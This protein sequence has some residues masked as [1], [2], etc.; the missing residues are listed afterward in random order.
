VKDHPVWEN[1][2]FWEEYFF[3]SLANVFREKFGERSRGFKKVCSVES[4]IVDS[5]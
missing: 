2:S 3:D 1:L 4:M 5:H